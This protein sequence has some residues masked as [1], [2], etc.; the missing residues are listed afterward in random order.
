MSYKV[1]LLHILHIV[2]ILSHVV[3]LN[4]QVSTK[5]YSNAYVTIIIMYSLFMIIYIW[6]KGL[7]LNLRT[8]L[9]FPDSNLHLLF[10][11][12]ESNYIK[13]YQQSY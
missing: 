2:H 3:K 4:P 8:M 10:T 9:T 5:C 13:P 1:K 11:N 7:K 12:K 6:I